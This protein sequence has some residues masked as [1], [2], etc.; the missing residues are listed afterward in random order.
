M[1][2]PKTHNVNGFGLEEIEEVSMSD[3]K[4]K[5]GDTVIYPE[6]FGS[7][8]LIFVGMAKDLKYSNDCVVIYDGKAVPVRS[9][10]LYIQN[11]KRKAGCAE[12]V[13]CG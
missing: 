3:K 2:I 8:E 12:A 10:G 13:R 9:C 4:F 11:T 7:K 6:C 1:N 5:N